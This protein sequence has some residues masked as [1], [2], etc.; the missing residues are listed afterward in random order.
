MARKLNILLIG[1]S[2]ITLFLFSTCRNPLAE[3]EKKQKII[4][5]VDDYIIDTGRY[6]FYWEGLDENNKYIQPGKYIVLLEIK[7]WQ[8]Q[9]FIEAIRG[10]TKGKNDESRF[11]PGYWNSHDLE[12]P[13][14]NPY[15]IQSGINIPVL[16][17]EPARV[18]LT[19]YKD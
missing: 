4:I 2:I 8:D 3:D 17:S 9:E 5:L 13:Y 7:D 11:E 16:L 10:G 1:I 12:E 6:I 14:P 19:V 15:E 18:K